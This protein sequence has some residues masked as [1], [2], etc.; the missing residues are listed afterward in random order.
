MNVCEDCFLPWDWSPDNRYLLYWPQSR[1]SIGLLDVQSR[2]STT[3]P[4]EQ[5]VSRSLRPRLAGSP[6][7]RSNLERAVGDGHQ[8]S[9]MA[10]SQSEHPNGDDR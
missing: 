1:R 3:T 6:D 2:Q 5:R 4:L 8:P 10:I 7:R 9:P